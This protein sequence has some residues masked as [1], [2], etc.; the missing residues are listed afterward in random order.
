[1]AVLGDAAGM[2]DPLSGEGIHSAV[3]S[4]RLLA[5]S[6]RECLNNGSAGLE[7]YQQAVYKR[8]MP[9]IRIARVL[10]KIFIHFPHVPVKLLNY[11]ARAWRGCCYFARGEMSYGNAR[12]LIGGYRGMKELLGGVLSSK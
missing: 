5:A 11:D 3:Y 12:Q 6:I 2:A 7:N 10:Q 8:I 9:E 1:M 4:A